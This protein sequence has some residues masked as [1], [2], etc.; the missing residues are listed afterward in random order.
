MVTM[1]GV[2][3][4]FSLTTRPEEP[5]PIAFSPWARTGASPRFIRKR[6]ACKAIDTSSLTYATK[7]D[8][9]GCFAS[10]TSWGLHR[11]FWIPEG[12]EPGEGVYVQYHSEELYAILS[13]ESHRSR[14]VLVGEN[15]G[16]VPSYVNRAMTRHNIRKIYVL[17]YS[18]APGAGS[19]CA[20]FQAAR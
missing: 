5:L 1:P 13:L 20:P 15:L 14:T 17:Q 7:C 3:S 11:L 9:P 16:T 8:T 18:I 12:I 10:I 4:A 6:F 19:P 2:S